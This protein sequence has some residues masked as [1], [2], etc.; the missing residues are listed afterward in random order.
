MKNSISKIMIA[1]T[2]VLSFSISSAQIKN[3]TTTSVKV[4][5]NCGMCKK[6]IENAGTVKKE[7]TVAWDKD[8]KMA[9]LTYDA[10]KTN[11]DA[12]LKRIALAGYDSNSFLAPDDVY[13]NLHGCCQYDRE[14]K[15]PVKPEI[16]DS[17]EAT[18]TAI[19]VTP[20]L[21]ASADAS[22]TGNQELKSVFESYF[23]VKDA[24]VQTD[25]AKTATQAT[26]LMTALKAVNMSALDM[27]VH[28]VW[29]KVV[30][31]LKKE[32][33]A[34]AATKATAEQRTHFE[35]LSESMY[36]LMKVSPQATPVYYQ[37]CPMAHDG[38]GANW[39]SKDAAVKNP[40]FGA[41][42]L[43]CGSTV[44]ILK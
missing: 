39:L 36:Q 31:E 42:M 5:G 33:Q 30:P 25:A 20:T 3:A 1:L 28:M 43:S 17:T 12:I 27:K 22:T 8:T 35:A 15:T 26:A 23:A 6:T 19:A 18:F 34:I 2:L 7:A 40:Y 14:A 32:A 11:P 24:L 21:D 4:Y 16:T 41:K 13:A 44:E 29:M 10:A 9:S 37:H 38:K